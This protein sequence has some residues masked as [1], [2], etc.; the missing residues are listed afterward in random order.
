MESRGLKHR[1]I[2]K[3]VF[4]LHSQVLGQRLNKVPQSDWTVDRMALFELLAP[5][6]SPDRYIP[7]PEPVTI[8]D[9][10]VSL[11]WDRE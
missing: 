2:T 5:P 8:L 4:G 10:S 1:R 6:D 9:T 3:L 7:I 11:T